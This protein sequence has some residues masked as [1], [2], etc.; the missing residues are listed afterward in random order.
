[1]LAQNDRETRREQGD[2]LLQ[3][4]T[5]IE[6]EQKG[7]RYTAWS[8]HLGELGW[9]YLILSVGSIPTTST[10]SGKRITETG[11]AQWLEGVAFS[12]PTESEDTVAVRDC[13]EGH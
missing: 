8:K 2:S 9:L 12:R 10:G 1:M 13:G 7:N 5:H 3:P 4:R 11:E 6:A